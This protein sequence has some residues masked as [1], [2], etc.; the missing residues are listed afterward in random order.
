M[1]KSYCG[2]CGKEL[3]D[4]GL[5]PINTYLGSTAAGMIMRN[6]NLNIDQF[7]ADTGKKRVEHVW[8]C[9]EYVDV[10]MGGFLSMS[11]VE[12]NNGH[13]IK[14]QMETE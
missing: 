1:N 7:D 3:V 14:I 12:N 5:F 6:G 10:K 8:E 11:F 4:K 13:R 2:K 9:P